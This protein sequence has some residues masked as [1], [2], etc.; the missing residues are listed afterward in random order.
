MVIAIRRA[1][2]DILVTP[3]AVLTITAFKGTVISYGK[4]D[5]DKAGLGRGLVTITSFRGT[6]VA[7]AEVAEIR[8]S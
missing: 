7:Y 3:R 5:G 6:V 8:R 1:I 2:H 4:N